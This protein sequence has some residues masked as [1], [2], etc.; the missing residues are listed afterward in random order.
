MNGKPVNPS[1]GTAT[2]GLSGL[3]RCHDQDSGRLQREQELR[4]GKYLGIE[5]FF[6]NNG[7]LS[8]ERSVNEQGNSQGRVREFWPN[9]Q[10]KRE[11][12]AENG[13]THGLVRSFT[14]TGQPD[15][16]R[17]VQDRQDVFSLEYNAQGQIAGLRCPTASVA[18]EDR[19]PCGFEGRT[20]TP[21]YGR[22]GEKLALRTYEQGRLLAASRW[23]DDGALA[24]QQLF[25]SGRRVQRHFSTEG[26]TQGKSVLREERIFEPDT[27]ALNATRGQLQS[28]KLWGANGQLTE[29]HHYADG[30][31]VALERWYLN[32]ALRE[33]RASSGTGE[34]ARVLRESF[35]DAGVLLRRNR[36]VASP[37]DADVPTGVQQTFRSDGKLAAE[38]TWSAPDVHGRT[39]LVARRLWDES[40]RLT[41]DDDILEDGS[42]Q[43]RAHTLG[44]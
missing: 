30:R 6:D 17:F 33:R 20:D 29:A 39:R 11:S 12:H 26:T 2:A 24:D 35:S 13:D 41:A 42:R 37:D 43:P 15:S 9:G 27:N 18:N 21:L 22:H 44:S 16:V 36:Y 3:L 1:D 28:L 40:G 23:Q 25:D 7:K 31:E 19:K 8:K 5:R 14:S 34:Q 38:E 10:L 4:A 32:G